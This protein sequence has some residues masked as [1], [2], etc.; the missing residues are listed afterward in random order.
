M[1]TAHFVDHSRSERPEHC[2]RASPCGNEQTEEIIE[3]QARFSEGEQQRFLLHRTR[4]DARNEIPPSPL[5]SHGNL[6]STKMRFISTRTHGITDYLMG[7]LLIAS[8]YLLNFATGGPAQWIPIIIGI[9]MLA[10]ALMTKYEVG[11]LK[12]IPMPAHLTV[13]F[14]AGA[15]LAV[16]PWLFGFSDIVFWPHLIMG[17]LEMGLALTTQTR[18]V[19]HGSSYPG[20]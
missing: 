12:A 5:G 3:V 19:D 16:S 8:P 18:P 15:L 11:M 13:D 1:P 10:M 14:L 20:R 6:E 7:I 17:I 2:C 9:A 4:L